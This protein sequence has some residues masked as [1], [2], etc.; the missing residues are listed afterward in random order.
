[1]VS[2]SR[3]E[4]HLRSAVAGRAFAPSMRWWAAGDGT[5]VAYYDTGSAWVAVGEP[6]AP[7]ADCAAVARCFVSAAADAQRRASFFG[8]E[9]AIDGLAHLELGSQPFFAI[10]AWDR[11]LADHRSLR[12]QLRRARNKGVVTR[13]I[14]ADELA[15]GT[16][17]R[18]SLDRALEAWASARGME[19]LQFVVAV[20]PVRAWDPQ[21]HLGAFVDDD[22]VG[23]ISAAYL[24]ASRTWIVE[25]IVRTPGAPNG[26]AEMLLDGVFRSVQM[27]EWVTLGL[28]PLSGSAPWQRLARWVAR[29]LYDFGGLQAFKSRLH[30]QA[31]RPVWL[32]YPPRSAAPIAVVDS[33]RAFA[34]GSLL[35]FAC[36]TLWRRPGAAPLALALP[37]VPWTVLLYV[38]AVVGGV[39]PLGFS[40]AAL[41]G[42]ALYDSV[43]IVGM[44]RAARAPKRLI[45]GLLWLAAAIDASVSLAHVLTIGFGEGLGRPLLR[46][47]ATVAPLLATAFLMRSFVLTLHARFG[48]S[49]RKC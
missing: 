45:I 3:G 33:L 22:L 6:L 47:V 14:R 26:C 42:W 19:P 43:L 46:C 31:W 40:G 39:G 7:R 13:C 5:G 24:P 8:V 17:L 20:D 36:R 10:A 18:S 49:Q 41:W 1:M 23:L 48:R 25:H 9:S 37:L 35:G 30:P 44:F 12:A 11:T 2:A 4:R 21:L 27:G 34:G 16:R 38:L 29:P 32:A 15:Q 28:A